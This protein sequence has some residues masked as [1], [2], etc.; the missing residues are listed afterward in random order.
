M[1]KGIY[2]ESLGCWVIVEQ[3][4]EKVTKI[5]FSKKAPEEPS[6]LAAEIADYL[7]GRAPCPEAELD[8]SRLTDFERQI[9]AIVQSIPR[10]ETATYGEVAERA[11]RPGAARAVGQVMAHNPFAILVPCHRVVAKEGLGGF[12]WGLGLKQRLLILEKGLP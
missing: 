5:G 7:A 2:I 6:A 12:A 8:L 3:S 9:S 11:G 10:G 4:E 1:T